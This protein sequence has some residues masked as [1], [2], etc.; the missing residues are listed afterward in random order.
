[1]LVA[2]A[3]YGSIGLFPAV[4]FPGLFEANG[5]N[6][7]SVIPI[8]QNATN[9]AFSLT[10]ATA[11]AIVWKFNQAFCGA[12][13]IVMLLPSISVSFIVSHQNLVQN[14]KLKEKW[15]QWG[16]QFVCFVLPWILCVPMQTGNWV[17]TVINWTGVLFVSPANFVIPFLIYFKCLRFRKTHE[18]PELVERKDPLPP[19]FGLKVIEWTDGDIS[20][21]AHHSSEDKIRVI[22]EPPTTTTTGHVH[23]EPDFNDIDAIPGSPKS[24]IIQRLSVQR[25]PSIAPSS[26]RLS[27]LRSLDDD[28]EFWLRENVPDP[29]QE[30][31]ENE[32]HHRNSGG[33]AVSPNRRASILPYALLKF[34]SGIL[35]PPIRESARPS[36]RNSSVTTTTGCADFKKYSSEDVESVVNMSPRSL[37]PLR[38]IHSIH[39]GLRASLRSS[40]RQ[41]SMERVTPGSPTQGPPAST[42]VGVPK[43]RIGRESVSGNEGAVALRDSL[44]T[45][46]DENPATAAA[47]WQLKGGE[48]DKIL[49]AIP[50]FDRKSSL[51]G[52]DEEGSDYIDLSGFRKRNAFMKPRPSVPFNPKFVSPAFRAVPL[53]LPIEPHRLA[54]FFLGVTFLL[55]VAVICLQMY[56]FKVPSFGEHF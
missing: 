33:T 55:T 45:L 9:L 14:F 30:L 24:A 19:Q 28:N 26:S 10:D 22:V 32:L 1:M 38:V 31:L 11:N 16:V 42:F 35:A 6:I 20:D 36:I 46:S 17:S 5:T 15:Q 53:W 4:A 25:H 37:S 40:F 2:I 49:T 52:D 44:Q 12:F 23:N 47:A 13:A 50:E 41:P 29:E 27:S 3:V 21:T 34:S 56:S 54:G 39:D 43:I 7:P 51:K 18:A 48:M 8:F